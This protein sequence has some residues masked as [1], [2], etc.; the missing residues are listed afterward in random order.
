MVTLA[1]PG[2]ACPDPFSGPPVRCVKGSHCIRPASG[3]AGTCVA[4]QKI[5]EACDSKQ[6]CENLLTCRNDKCALPVYAPCP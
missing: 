3:Q 5:G 6:R 2:D 1:Q 4:S